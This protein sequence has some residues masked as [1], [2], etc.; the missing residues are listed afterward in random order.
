LVIHKLPW[1]STAGACCTAPPGE[2][3]VSC[4]AGCSTGAALLGAAAGRGPP[5]R[6][7]QSSGGRLRQP[8]L[9]QYARCGGAARS[10]S[11]RALARPLTPSALRSL[12]SR[13]PSSGLG[14][15]LGSLMS[16]RGGKMGPP[17]SWK[18]FSCGRKGRR[19]GGAGASAASGG[20]GGGRARRPGGRGSARARGACARRPACTHARPQRQRLPGR[21]AA[22]AAAARGCRS[23]SGSGCPAGWLLQAQG[24][25]CRSACGSRCTW[26]SA[27]RRCP[28]ARRAAT[29]A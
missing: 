2:G 19:A 13:P 8:L 14:R 21:L 27:R 29:R 17:N 28:S 15:L 4:A 7:A 26:R 10:S 23:S 25:R 18:I 6:A 22:A 5:Q 11:R 9:L 3:G 24:S 12:H 16:S 20:G 1:C